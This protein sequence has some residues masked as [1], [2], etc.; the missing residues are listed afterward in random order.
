MKHKYVPLLRFRIHVRRGRPLRQIAELGTATVD[1]DVASR[2][3]GE[4]PILHSDHGSQYTSAAYRDCLEH[5]GLTISMGRVR[6]CADNVS[7]VSVFSQLKR[8]LVYRS[9]FRTRQEASEKLDSYFLK[10]YNPL[11]RASLNRNALEE[12]TRLD[13]TER[14]MKTA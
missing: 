6:K 1:R 12:L 5:H 4:R 8:E 14:G 7:A 11:R 2:L 13:D 3:D 10:T 9:R